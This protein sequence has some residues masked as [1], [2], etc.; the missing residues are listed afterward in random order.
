MLALFFSHNGDR[1]YSKF[2]AL[3]IVYL[4]M[5]Y[6]WMHKKFGVRVSLCY[7]IVVLSGVMSMFSLKY[8]VSYA[9]MNGTITFLVITLPFLIL[10]NLSSYIKKILPVICVTN[11]A[12]ILSQFAFGTTKVGLFDGNTSMNA[13]IIGITL[14]FLLD[15]VK[16]GA[17]TAI[18]ISSAILAVLISGQSIPF[19]CL[20]LSIAFYYF[21][22]FRSLAIY[23]SLTAV[24]FI[25][26]GLISQKNM[27]FF[28]SGRFDVYDHFMRYWYENFN[29]LTGT[30]TGTF[31]FLG[32]EEQFKSGFKLF[33][34]GNK[35]KG[36]FGFLHSDFLQIV[37][38]QGIA[39]MVA[40]M[41]LL[42][43][44][45]VTAWKRRYR[46]ILSAG[47]AYVGCMMF[48]YPLR[49]AVTSMIGC[50]IMYLFL[51]KERNTQ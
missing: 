28:S 26:L 16:D 46:S 48:N 38:E 1:Y 42:I 33:Q 36:I 17:F 43:S 25:V 34:S 49:L 6:Y 30:G 51:Q 14:P 12:F 31:Q 8:D 47:M 39:G 18:A 35:I 3:F 21:R 27:F 2:K 20:F 37:F 23:G 29:N 9:A 13:C 41:V 45:L 10:D 44:T 24:G 11:I 7:L 50:S 40:F 5:I 32:K 4:A 22:D 15:V 19:G